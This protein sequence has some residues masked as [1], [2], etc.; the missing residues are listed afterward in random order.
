MRRTHTKAYCHLS[1]QLKVFAIHRIEN[2]EITTS[3]FDIDTKI[4]QDIKKYGLFDYPRI[5]N[6]RLHCQQKTVG[7]LK[8][9][10]TSK[11]LTLEEQEDGSLIVTIPS[12]IEHELLHWV[13]GEAG[14]VKVLYPQILVDK[15]IDAASHLLERH[16]V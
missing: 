13:L 6:V 3:V 8:E 11:N 9:Q 12:V 2:I 10:A 15:V 4:T 14:K 16:Q 5:E 1:E 7:Y